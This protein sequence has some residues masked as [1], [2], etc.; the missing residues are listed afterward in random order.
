[1]TLITPNSALFHKTKAIKAPLLADISISKDIFN[2]SVIFAITDT[3]AFKKRHELI[4]FEFYGYF[5]MLGHP[6]QLIEYN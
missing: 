6:V 4:L 2:I 1:M 5:K 3:Q